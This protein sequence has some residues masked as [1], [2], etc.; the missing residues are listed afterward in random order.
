MIGETSTLHVRYDRF[1]PAADSAVFER[2]ANGAIRTTA[3]V[4]RVGIYKYQNADGSVRRELVD[5]ETLSDPEWLASCKGMPITN[6]H[7]PENVTSVNMRQ[8]RIGVAL[9]AGEFKKPFHVQTDFQIDAA[10]GL[11]AL[12]FGRVEVSPG[13]TCETVG[14]AGVHAEYGAYDVI[15]RNRRCNHIA[16]CDNARGGSEC[17]ILRVDS[18]DSEVG[19]IQDVPRES[20]VDAVPETPVELPAMTLTPVMKDVLDMLKIKHDEAMCDEDAKALIARKIEA[21]EGEKPAATEPPKQDEPA[22]DAEKVDEG[23]YSAEALAKIAALEAEVKKAGEAKVAAEVALQKAL[24]EHEMA[25]MSK[26]YDEAMDDPD[27]AM[28]DATKMDSAR[29]DAIKAKRRKHF[30]AFNAL[31]ERR[32]RNIARAIACGL[33]REDAVKLGNRALVKS[34]ALKVVPALGEN[35]STAEYETALFTFESVSRRVDSKPANVW[36]EQSKRVDAIVKVD[37]DNTETDVYVATV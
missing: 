19:T 23:A 5:E 3:N 7:P 17:R 9:S 35:R 27:G 8:Y 30:D 22:K 1:T 6:D 2:L 29:L 33:K 16:I 31:C 12:D 20:K 34:A 15:Q 25:D 28:M 37:P 32:E 26:A 24:E 10:D 18:T 13:Y 36:E 11:D 4:A 14:P 21:E